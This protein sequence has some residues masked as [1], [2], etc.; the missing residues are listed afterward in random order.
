MVIYLWV[1][2][3]YSVGQTKQVL[4]DWFDDDIVTLERIE[5][6]FKRR[7]IKVRE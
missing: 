1:R 3:Y 7:T 5:D 2:D 6:Y 4:D